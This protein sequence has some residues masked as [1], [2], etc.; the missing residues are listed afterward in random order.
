MSQSHSHVNTLL[1][2][3]L[4]CVPFHTFYELLH[5]LYYV[6]YVQSNT[7]ASS[8]DYICPGIHILYKRPFLPAPGK[9]LLYQNIAY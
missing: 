8:L 9:I 4:L 2:L 7:P 1:Y 5:L 6:I 3:L